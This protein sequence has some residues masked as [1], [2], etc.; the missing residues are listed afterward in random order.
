MNVD[1]DEL[2][3][4]KT[5]IQALEPL[6]MAARA[7]VLAW[8]AGRFQIAHL[9]QAAGLPRIGLKSWQHGQ[10]QPASFA[11]LFDM[12][13]PGPEKEKA[14]VA[15]YWT[16]VI[17]GNE[18]FGSQSLNFELKNLGHGVGNITDALSQLLRERPAL[19]LQLRKSG[20]SKQARKTYKLTQAGIERVHEMIGRSPAGGI[21]RRTSRPAVSR[22]RT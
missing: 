20:A 6:D 15:A 22:S 9:G 10:I 4:M 14:L 18:S 16:Q 12:A 8:A 5:I 3:A 1:D 17:E 19:V 13:Q 7:R 11:E 21:T 2:K